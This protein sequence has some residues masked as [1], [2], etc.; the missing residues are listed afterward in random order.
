MMV[1]KLLLF[2]AKMIGVA[3][4]NLLLPLKELFPQLMTRLVLMEVTRVKVQLA[5]YLVVPH[6]HL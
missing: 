1:N 4:K 2:Q 5:P 6:P 3:L